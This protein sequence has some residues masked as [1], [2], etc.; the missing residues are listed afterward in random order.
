MSSEGENRKVMLFPQYREFDVRLRLSRIEPGRDHVLVYPLENVKGYESPAPVRSELT[1]HELQA[2]RTPAS[3][4]LVS[5]MVEKVTAALNS[6]PLAWCASG[7]VV[8]LDKI[9]NLYTVNVR[10]YV[11]SIGETPVA[12]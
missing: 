4:T 5:F 12:L 3:E 9:A 7:A 8:R 10:P 1:D 2:S 11:G 6:N